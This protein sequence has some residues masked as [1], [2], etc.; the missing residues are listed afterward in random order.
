MRAYERLTTPTGGP[1][2]LMISPPRP[3]GPIVRYG[4]PYAAIAKLSPDIRAFLAM[5]DGLRALGFSTPRVYAHSVADGLALLEDFGAETIA[6]DRG[7]NPARYAEA[8]ALLAELH[9][10]SLPAELPVDGEIYALPVYDIEAM[11]VEVE[12]ALDWYAPAVARVAPSSG[13]RVQFLGAVAR[14]ARAD[15]RAARHLDLARLPFAQSALA[16]RRAGIA[17]PRPDRLPGRRARAARL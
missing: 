2:I 6:D 5:A 10:R 15:P 7:P 8:T 11:L 14:R 3:D 9:G 16:G 4:K 1:P 13:A 12:L 17:A